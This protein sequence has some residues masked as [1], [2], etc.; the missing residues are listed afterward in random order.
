MAH[1]RV[2]GFYEDPVDSFSRPVNVA[3]SWAAYHFEVHARK[4]AYCHNSY[5]VYR[6]RENL[7]EVGHGLAQQIARYIYMKPDGE[8]YS[9]SEEDKKLVR[10][11]LP[12]G[13]VEVQSLVKA[14]ERSIRHNSR[15]SS[16]GMDRSYHVSPRTDLVSTIRSHPIKV[17]QESTNKRSSQSRDGEIVDWPSTPSH[18]RDLSKR[19]LSVEYCDVYT[20]EENLSGV[21][22]KTEAQDLQKGFGAKPKELS[23][24]DQD[25]GSPL[26]CT[27]DTED[28]DKTGTQKATSDMPP[29]NTGRSAN[30]DHEDDVSVTLSDDDSIFSVPSLASS[31][32]EMSKGSGYSATQ[33]AIATKEVLSI[34]RDDK[35]L[36]PLYTTAIYGPIGPR[37][38]GNTFRRLLKSFSEN[39]KDEAQDRLD[40]LAARLV[41]LK[42]RDIADAI[43]ERYQPGHA[44]ALDADEGKGQLPLD[45]DD[46]DPSDE[47]AYVDETI[48]GDLTNVREFLVQSAAFKLLQTNLQRFVFLR[49]SSLKVLNKQNNKIYP[50]ERTI[51]F[52][53]VLD[54][55]CQPPELRQTALSDDCIDILQNNRPLRQL[56][57]YTLSVLGED[58]FVTEYSKLLFWSYN[59]QNKSVEHHLST[60]M[61]TDWTPIVLDIVKYLRNVD[62]CNPDPKGQTPDRQA[63][64]S[65]FQ[66]LLTEKESSDRTTVLDLLSGDLALLTLRRPLREAIV[67][68]PKC[69]I[70]LCSM[71]NT[72]LLNKIEA[73]FEDYTM[74]EWD[75]W[76]LTPRVPDIASGDHRL[77]WKFGGVRLYEI[78]SSLERNIIQ[79]AMRS[80]PQHP[81]QCHCRGVNCPGK[82]SDTTSQQNPDSIPRLQI[83]PRLWSIA[84]TLI[85]STA[86]RSSGSSASSKASQRYTPTSSSAVPT[87]TNNS[88]TTSETDT[89]SLATDNGNSSPQIS[90]QSATVLAATSPDPSKRV[91]FA[92]QGSRWSLEV[93]QI[94]ITTLLNDPMFFRELKTR[95][96]KHRS[97]IKRLASPFRFRFCRF[98][99]LEKFDTGRVLS[100][101]ED[102]PDYPGFENDYEYDPRPGTNP[103]ISPKTIASDDAMAV[104]WGLEAEH[105]IS[106]AFMAVY[107][108]VPLLAAFGFWIYWL[109][110]FPGDWQNA[111]VPV[112]T[113]LA[114][115]AVLWVPFGKHLGTS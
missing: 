36:Q 39:L 57:T 19:R 2:V 3:E 82:A 54:L 26:T 12:A 20:S 93:E 62:T 32:S 41:A 45:Y 60:Q 30:S 44:P 66:I 50:E 25:S 51:Q 46:Q 27:T 71:N 111:A 53:E 43:L 83:V 61:T 102:L 38:F 100:Q 4:C 29:Y 112:L 9:T 24:I 23:C 89:N 99:K 67:S 34:F 10:L 109:M 37:K 28:E 69:T 13:Y 52:S 88:Q 107:H 95:Y 6:N 42:V 101:G 63:E 49:K 31:A 110:K 15:E 21:S 96:R 90:G 22:N 17:E 113:V 86:S 59:V 70:E 85:K 65:F 81:S 92:V 105:A 8:I 87:S 97:W 14:V 104:A 103:M 35:I 106:F 72:S 18:E 40:F 98:V 75:W 108:L 76:P 115:F 47:D 68:A 7:C 74:A 114:L 16:T 5:E 73:F 48:F 55:L 78:V 84:A 77:Q 1:D 94:S 91:L 58:C 64:T 33:I 80:L 79:F 11:E 56:H